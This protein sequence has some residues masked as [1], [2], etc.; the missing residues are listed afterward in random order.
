MKHKP[1]IKMRHIIT[2]VQVLSATYQK[3]DKQ[4][5]KKTHMWMFK[6]SIFSLLFDFEQE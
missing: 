3:F 2:Y 5:L 6:G 1:K 4:R